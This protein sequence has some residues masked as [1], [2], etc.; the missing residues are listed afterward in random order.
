MPTGNPLQITPIIKWLLENRGAYNLR[1]ALDVGIGFCKYGLLFREYLAIYG[2]H[3]HTGRTNVHGERVIV[4]GVEPFAP[5][6]VAPQA[7]VYDKIAEGPF[8]EFPLLRL[9]FQKPGKWYDIVLISDVLEH[10]TREVGTKAIARAK[11]LGR[12]VILGVPYLAGYG[13]QGAE[14]GNQWETHVSEWT[15]EDFPE[16]RTLGEFPEWQ[17]CTPSFVGVWGEGR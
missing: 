5:Y 17:G 11:E 1:S 2:G 12:F 4:D 3:D 14:F 15:R 13:M 6:R 9:R 16:F 10:M 8:P 7:A